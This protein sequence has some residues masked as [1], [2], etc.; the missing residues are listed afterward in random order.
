[1]CVGQLEYQ[2]PQNTLWFV[3]LTTV[4]DRAVAPQHMGLQYGVEVRSKDRLKNGPQLPH[5]PDL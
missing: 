3:I 1:M 4:Q 5:I 2:A